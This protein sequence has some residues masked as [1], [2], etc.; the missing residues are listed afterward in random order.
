MV[1]GILRKTNDDRKNNNEAKPTTMK[2][3]N[4][5]TQSLETS[6]LFEFWIH[7]C[8]S[9]VLTQSAPCIEH[10][11]FVLGVV[12]DFDPGYKAFDHCPFTEVHLLAASQSLHLTT[13]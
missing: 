1:M 10:L 2:T 4:C 11:V 7:P 3:I 13:P 9:V 12:W 6:T 5:I 8:E